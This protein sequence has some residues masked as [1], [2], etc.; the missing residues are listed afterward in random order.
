RPS[1]PASSRGGGTPGW[2]SGGSL[3]GRRCGSF[4]R[5]VGRARGAEGGK[6]VVWGGLEDEGRRA[7]AG[8]AR[9]GGAPGSCGQGG[10]VG[11]REGGARLALWGR[12]VWAGG[13]V[14]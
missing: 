9:R 10:R 1:L 6:G 14:F 8:A 3:G 13:W 2:L 5:E 4:A 12:A 7:R 11:L